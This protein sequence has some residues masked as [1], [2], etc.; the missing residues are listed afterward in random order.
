MRSTV[1]TALLM[2]WWLASLATGSKSFADHPLIGSRRLNQAG[3]HVGRVRLAHAMA[4]SRRRRLSAHLSPALREAFDRDGYVIVRDFLPPDTFAA[5]LKKLRTWQGPCRETRQGNTI[6]RRMPIDRQMLAAIPGLGEVLKHPDWRGLTRYASTFDCE[7]IS[8]IQ[9]I[10]ASADPRRPDPQVNL[11]ADAFQPS[12]K[13]WLFL[14]DVSEKSGP[15]TYVRGSHRLTPERLEW[16]RSMSLRAQQADRLTARGSFRITRDELGQ[17]GLPPPTALAVPANTLIVADT[18]G[19][20]ARAPSL[21]PSTRVELWGY[22]RRNPF[23]PWTG[24]APLSTKALAPQRAHLY[25]RTRDLLAS[26]WG[27]P[28]RDTGPKGPFDPV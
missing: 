24:L 20:H 17:L 12:A 9:T 28:W 26:I 8:Y 16:E 10:L 14:E 3:L 1:R 27:Q 18:F 13:A 4:R 15:L 22:A 21:Q 7:P 25:W 2:P 5:L 19:F 6:T 11:H 23:L